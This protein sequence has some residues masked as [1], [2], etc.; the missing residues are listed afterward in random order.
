MMFQTTKAEVISLQKRPAR[1][2][3]AVPTHT[4]AAT[5]LALGVSTAGAQTLP[6]AP[7]AGRLLQENPSM[8]AAPRAA[9]DLRFSPPPAT[10]ASAAGGVHVALKEVRIEPVAG[11]DVARL[12]EAVGPVQGQSFDLQGLRALADRVTSALHAMGYPFARAWLPQQDLASGV[13]NINVVE[14]RYGNVQA[15]SG[16]AALA[17]EAQQWLAPLHP[18]DAI[19][20]RELHRSL[21]LLDELPGVR[22]Q[23][24]LRP[25]S[26]AGTGDL[27]VQ[28]TPEKAFIGR[29]GVDNHGNRYAGQQRLSAELDAYPGLRLGDRIS[30]GGLLTAEQTW[31]GRAQYSTPVGHDGLRAHVQLARTDYELG[32]EFTALGA[33]G[34]ADTLEVGLGYPLL[35]S[36]NTNVRVGSTLQWR[37]LKDVRDAVASHERKQ[38]QALSV[39]LSADHRDTAGVTWGTVNWTPGRLQLEGAQ[40]AA[41][42]AS[43]NAAGAFQKINVDLARVQQLGQRLSGYVRIS[44]Q[45]A[46]SNLDSSE[47]FVLGGPAGVRAWPTGEA[48]G[49]EGALVQLELRWQLDASWQPYGFVDAGTVNIN[50]RPWLAGDNRRSIAGAGF[51]IRWNQNP[52]SLD[53]SV[54][55]RDSRFAPVSDPHASRHQIW[56]SLSYRL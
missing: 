37:W 39:S 15:S 30:L 53:T 38:T 18:G 3:V 28:V 56:L 31:Q 16:D 40:L 9:P 6:A 5:L 7:D 52:W 11:I 51:G 14:G 44:T 24:R 41:D 1:E 42:R 21:L 32:K 8:P 23:A 20:E 55:R 48:V 49:D 27:I 54:S 36:V 45:W 22:S 26:D 34:T 35:R 43:A 13:L 12:Q 33:H 25:G 29:V 50:Q 46:S 2:S 47:K 4:L 17:S 19:R 10:S